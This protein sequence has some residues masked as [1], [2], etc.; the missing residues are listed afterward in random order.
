MIQGKVDFT[1]NTRWSQL[2]CR[3]NLALPSFQ[4]YIASTYHLEYFDVSVFKQWPSIN[5]IISQ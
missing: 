5:D 2:E 4:R 1:L 3:H